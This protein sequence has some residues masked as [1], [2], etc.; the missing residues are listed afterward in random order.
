MNENDPLLTEAILSGYQARIAS[1]DGWAM[2]MRLS[3]NSINEQGEAA[4]ICIGVEEIGVT[5]AGVKATSTNEVD[6][7][8]SYW[9]DATMIETLKGGNVDLFSS[10]YDSDIV[11]QTYR[12]LNAWYI[13]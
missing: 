9:F 8:R 7:Y 11:E 4:A 5:C 12:G 3:H 6:T 13:L 1:Y 10:T 2:S